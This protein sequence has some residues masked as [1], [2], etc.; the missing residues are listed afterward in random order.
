MVGYVSFK[1]ANAKADLIYG[2]RLHIIGLPRGTLDKIA[3]KM[4]VLANDMSAM[5]RL[6]RAVSLSKLEEIG[7]H[8]GLKL[9][10]RWEREEVKE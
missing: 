10:M 1:H 9:V 6:E 7:N 5:L 2:L 3:A 4:G 8:A